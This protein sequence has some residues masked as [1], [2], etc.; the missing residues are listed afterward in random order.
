[1]AQALPNTAA[2]QR[3]DDLLAT[4]HAVSTRDGKIYDT[5]KFTSQSIPGIEINAAKRYI[6]VTAQGHVNLVWEH[7]GAAVPTPI[8]T[9]LPPIVAQTEAIGDHI[10]FAQNCTKDIA[11]VRNKGFE[12]DNDN[13]TAPKN[14]PG[15]DAPPVVNGGLYAGQSW[16]WNRIDH[17]QMA[18]G[19]DTTSHLSVRVSPP[20]GRPTFSSLCIS[21]R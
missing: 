20:L 1:M 12:V 7:F 15:P 17:R 9:N 4:C 8:P 19:G 11:R 13:N 18:G 14:V 3:V 5:I 10:F 21:S 16:G 6:V 2:N